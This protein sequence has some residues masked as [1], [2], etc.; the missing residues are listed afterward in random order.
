MSND[1]SLG[2]EE[3]LR[4]VVREEIRTVLAELRPLGSDPIPI[5]QAAER[6]GVSVKTLRRMI[7]AGEITALRIRKK[8][9]IDMEQ[10]RVSERVTRLARDLSLQ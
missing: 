1:S 3:S 6:L 4:R 5:D 2:I 9:L 8:I 7:D 10:F